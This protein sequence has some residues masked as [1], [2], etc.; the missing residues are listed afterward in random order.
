MLDPRV[1]DNA[2]KIRKIREAI[3]LLADSLDGVAWRVA[4]PKE[5][6]MGINIAD[7][8]HKVLDGV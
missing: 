8:I 4:T 2:K 7:E 5:K 6:T 3:L 1:E